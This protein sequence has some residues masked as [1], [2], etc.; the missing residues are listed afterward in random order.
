MDKNKYFLT[1]KE[2]IYKI[3]NLDKIEVPKGY[4]QI[5]A[6][7]NTKKNKGDKDTK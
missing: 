1:F 5:D 3:D 6:Q 7:K 4:I 2:F